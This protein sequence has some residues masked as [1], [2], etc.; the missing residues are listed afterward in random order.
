MIAWMFRAVIVLAALY[1][2]FVLAVLR[3]Q[4]P[5]GAMGTFPLPQPEVVG[6]SG[7]ACAPGFVLGSGELKALDYQLD[8]G[9]ALIDGYDILVPKS[10]KPITWQYVRQLRGEQV[11]L[12]LRKREPRNPPQEL[13]R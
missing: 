4:Q 5:E 9:F 6:M 10:H 1:C 12:V 7:G 2:W 8:D 11:E 3:A 13:V